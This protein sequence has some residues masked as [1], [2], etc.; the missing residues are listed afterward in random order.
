[1]FDQREIVNKSIIDKYF[2]RLFV[3]FFS[4]EPNIKW[5]FADH[6]SICK[7]IFD[8]FPRV[9]AFLAEEH[10]FLTLK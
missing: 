4:P 8:F 9:Q 1:M 7:Q 6:L 5:A 3:C 10:S 2:T